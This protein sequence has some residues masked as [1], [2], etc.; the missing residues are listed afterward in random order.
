MIIKGK[1]A[2][3][4]DSHVGGDISCDVDSDINGTWW[5]TTHV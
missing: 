5:V 2:L 4:V 1:C 3:C